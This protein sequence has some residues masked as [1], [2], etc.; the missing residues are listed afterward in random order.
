MPDE[1]YEG[2][3]SAK[4]TVN[5]PT[6]VEKTV[7]IVKNGTTEVLPDEGYDY[8]RKVNINTEVTLNSVPIVPSEISL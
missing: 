7:N 5:I 3:A 1:G 8:I 2:I 4:V 6:Q